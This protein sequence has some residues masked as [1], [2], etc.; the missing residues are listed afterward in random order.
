[1]STP[2]D[3]T[4]FPICGTPGIGSLAVGGMAV[5]GMAVG[6][7]AVGG[8]SVGG[9]SVGQA[10]N[11]ND[12]FLAAGATGPA[13]EASSTR[14]Q[15]TVVA[16]KSTRQR[17]V[18]F[19]RLLPDGTAGTLHNVLATISQAVGAEVYAG[20]SD[21]DTWI[22]ASSKPQNHRGESLS[23]GIRSAVAEAAAESSGCLYALKDRQSSML[24]QAARQELV[25]AQ[26]L[27]FGVHGK[28]VKVGLLLAN[29]NSTS[30]TT[31]DQFSA[32]IK[33]VRCEL[34]EWFELWYLCLQGSKSHSWYARFR[35]LYGNRKTWLLVVAAAVGSLAI[36]VPYWPQ[37]QCIVE[38]ESRRFLTSPIDGRVVEAQVRPGD[39]VEPNQLLARID[40]ETIRWELANAEADYHKACKKR[41]TALATRSGGDLR[42]AQLE[43]EQFAI[44]IESLQSKL[45]Q[46]EIRSPIAGVVVDGDWVRTSGTAVERSQTLFEIAPLDSMRIRT[47]LSTEDL[48]RIPTGTPVTIHVDS[49]YGKKWTGS[50]ERI[51]PRG[52]IENSE[53]VFEA[54]TIVENQDHTLR[55]G[56]HGSARLTAGW[57]NL[58]WIIFHQP[59]TWLMKKLAW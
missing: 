13:I 29:C 53:V 11:G 22:I 3:S 40:D 6:G 43:S 26:V 38:P 49:A 28:S 44:H 15:A 33:Q 10:N 45:Q 50:I 39:V 9:T 2:L 57:H 23:S 55:P 48:G 34:A 21:N 1:V 16:D 4:S 36:P 59:Y 37:R 18:D 46:L 17:L 54:E 8:T 47:L 56:L 30:T 27:A 12:H 14:H 7:M 5:G 58:G 52:R 24:L 19:N 31:N 42:M 32:V 25:A 41:D 51:D 35:K 20:V